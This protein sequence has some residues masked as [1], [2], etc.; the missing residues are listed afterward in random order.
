MG[1]YCCC[2]CCCGRRRHRGRDAITDPPPPFLHMDDD[3]ADEV[4]YD[5]LDTHDREGEYD[6]H[7]DDRGG[8]EGSSNDRQRYP[9][10]EPTFEVTEEELQI[11][12]AELSEAYPSDWTYMDDAYLRSVA[13]KPYSK[14]M[15][16]RRPL[17]YT[18]EKL[19]HVMEWRREMQVPDME[20]WIEA[21]HRVDNNHKGNND[22]DRSLEALLPDKDTV[23]K[24]RKMVE[25][26]NQNH[27][28]WHGMTVDGRPILW[29]RTERKFWYPNVAAE[30]NA[31]V[32]MADAGIRYGMPKGVT[33][34]VAISHSHNPPPPQPAC[35]FQM[36]RGLVK[37]YPDRMRL[38]ISAPVGTI[39]EFI[40]N[41][42]LPHLPG[43]LAHK[44]SFY[45]M[46]HVQDKLEGL[47]WHGKDDIP[48][49]FGGPADHDAYYPPPTTSKK[50]KGSDVLLRFDWYGMKR[51][52]QEQKAAFEKNRQ[53]S[54]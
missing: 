40:M 10:V 33:D 23:Q 12:K 4:W 16:R 22:D 18:L 7:D 21:C 19:M 30:V 48:T 26:L 11:L 28:Y 14:D 43:R 45:K 8:G 36:L 32:C 38:L 13:S 52:L 25:S 50:N 15:S 3:W 2:L 39:I 6:D 5:A 1:N 51:R 54:S 24:A 41:L 53:L 34:F 20:G 29:I 42:I 9:N 31:L 44:F 27:M 17:D 47:L 37:G 46:E 35:I 49:F